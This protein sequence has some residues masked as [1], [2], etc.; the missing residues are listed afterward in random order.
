M[1][2]KYLL[3]LLIFL[4]GFLNIAVLT[5]MLRAFKF[6]GDVLEVGIISFIIVLI[7]YVALQTFSDEDEA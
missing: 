2:D 3:I 6:Q 5:L 7:N 4:F 1:H